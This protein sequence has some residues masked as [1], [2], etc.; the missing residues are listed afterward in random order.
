M[1]RDHDHGSK[2]PPL[3]FVWCRNDPDTLFILEEKRDGI[4]VRETKLRID[5]DTIPMINFLK[6]TFGKIDDPSEIWEF[7]R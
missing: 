5:A 2:P 6:K 4:T 7:H 1:D 3:R